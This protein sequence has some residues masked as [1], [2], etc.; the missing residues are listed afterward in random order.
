MS[1][2]SSLTALAQ[3]QFSDLSPSAQE[4][5]QDIGIDDELK[6][7]L[8]LKAKR[9]NQTNDT[10]DSTG[11]KGRHDNTSA[12]SLKVDDPDTIRILLLRQEISE[13][14]LASTLDLRVIIARI[15]QEGAAYSELKSYLEERRDQA[16]RRNNTANFLSNGALTMASNGWEIPTGET[17]ETIGAII[18]AVAGGVTTGISGWALKISGGEKRSAEIHPNML[19][20]L[21]NQ[22]V[23]SDHDYP[24]EIWRFMTDPMPQSATRESR[25]DRLLKRWVELKRVEQINTPQGKKHLAQLCGTVPQVNTV[26]I[27]LLDDRVAM[28]YDVKATV[29]LMFAQLLELMRA[30]HGR[31][32]KLSQ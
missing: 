31:Q 3:N 21:F 25:K 7:L 11:S 19:A 2:G 1:F 32:D 16:I 17:P 10:T 24:R 15:D 30:I 8:A 9:S 5:A 14:I 26:N 29:S 12:S 22:P 23:D 6:E 28:L 20:K 4:V 13:T 27:D 18:G